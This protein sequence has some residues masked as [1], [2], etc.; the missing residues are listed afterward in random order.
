M[1][2]RGILP[3]LRQTKVSEIERLLQRAERNAVRHA[4]R[5]AL[6][7]LGRVSHF[8]VDRELRTVSAHTFCAGVLD[9]T[10]KLC[11]DGL[12]AMLRPALSP[13]VRRR[14]L[15][16]EKRHNYVTKV[17]ELAVQNFITNDRPNVKG[18]VMAG[19]ADFKTVISQSDLFD[20]RLQAVIV[21]TIPLNNSRRAEQLTEGSCSKVRMQVV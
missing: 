5:S 17:A 13:L 12:R 9:C 19:S 16:E 4:V 18:I 1:F 14:R 8:A 20:K 15:R 2:R 21:A 10:R 3:P 6:P 11:G 7:G